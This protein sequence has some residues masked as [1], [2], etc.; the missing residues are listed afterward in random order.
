MRLMP[1]L[2]VWRVLTSL[3]LLGVLCFVASLPNGQ[4]FAPSNVVQGPRRSSN[5]LRRERSTGG[6]CIKTQVAAA[7]ARCRRCKQAGAGS[8][9][10][11]KRPIRSQHGAHEVR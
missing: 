8:T 7:A 4:R 6:W 5:V 1:G 9:T 3:T 11:H 2:G 10:L